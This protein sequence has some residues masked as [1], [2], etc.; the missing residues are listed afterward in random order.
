[1]KKIHIIIGIVIGMS[2]IFGV[3]YKLDC[4][5]AKPSMDDHEVLA[6][7]VRGI[8]MKNTQ[9]Q[10]WDIEDR[11]RGKPATMWSREDIDRYRRLQEY[12]KCLKDGKKGC[13]YYH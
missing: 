8:N 3:G 1:M 6:A 11:Y 12:M 13:V 7:D 4:R 9:Q 2:T 5:W 10:I